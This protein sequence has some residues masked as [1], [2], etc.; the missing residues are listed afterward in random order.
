MIDERLRLLQLLVGLAEDALDAAK[1]LESKRLK[2]ILS[3]KSDLVF[4]LS[5]ALQGEAP[6]DPAL[7]TALKSEAASLRILEQRIVVIS[8][9]ALSTFQAVMPRT[10]AATYGRAGTLQR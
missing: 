7:V 10:R 9:G 5:V 1:K 4:S 6:T 8:E 3:E 2:A